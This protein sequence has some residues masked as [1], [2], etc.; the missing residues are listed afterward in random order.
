MV[1]DE[2]KERQAAGKI[3]PCNYVLS[4]VIPC[5]NEKDT[6]EAIVDEVI[7]APIAKKEIIVVDNCSTDG[8]R[9]ILKEKIESKVAKVIYNEK[10]I[11][12]GGSLIRGFDA[13]TGDIVVVQDADL[14]YD[15]VKDYPKLVAPII[16][17]ETQV[18]YGSRF[19]KENHNTGSPLNYA[20][21]KILTSFS[22][23]M[24]G[25]NVTDV[26]TCYKTF[27]REAIKSINLVEHNFGFEPEVTGKIAQKGYTVKEVPVEYYPRPS[28]AGKKVKFRHGFLT[29]HCI[30]KY[31]NKQ[32][33]GKLL[34]QF[35]SYFIAG[36][37]AAVVN[38]LLFALFNEK[39]LLGW[40]VSTILSFVIALA[41]NLV[42]GR[43]T[44]FKKSAST[45]TLASDILP[46]FLVSAVGLAFDLLLMALFVEALSAPEMI[47]KIISTGIVFIWNFL[48]RRIFI[49]NNEN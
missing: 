34:K 20:A 13:A 39:M 40:S 8:T 41:V 47:S 49:Y 48:G 2:T 7:K 1:L 21:N 31:R 11:G 26:E 5:Y 27:S 12:K 38:W 3:D 16:A 46:V 14:E 15:P 25:L 42:M 9:E 17:G 29:L 32:A 37:T 24:T 22:N 30:I 10:N 6:I 23:M 33:V 18:V 35:A 43:L 19:I 4:V 36:G 28:S 45:R 44:T